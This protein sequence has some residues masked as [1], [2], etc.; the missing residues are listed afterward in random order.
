MHSSSEHPSIHFF[1]SLSLSKSRSMLTRSG[2]WVVSKNMNKMAK[3]NDLAV[4]TMHL[5][6]CLSWV[7][8]WTVSCL[9]LYKVAQEKNGEERRRPRGR[10]I[11]KGHERSQLQVFCLLGDIKEHMISEYTLRNSLWRLLPENDRWDKI[12]SHRE[13][14][15]KEIPLNLKM[16]ATCEMKVDSFMWHL[17]YLCKISYSPSLYS[18]FHRVLPSSFTLLSSIIVITKVKLHHTPTFIGRHWAKQIK[19]IGFSFLSACLDGNV[20]IAMNTLTGLQWC[21]APVKWTGWHGARKRHSALFTRVICIF[22]LCVT[23]VD[24]GEK[25]I[26]KCFGH[27]WVCIFKRGGRKKKVEPQTQRFT[28]VTVTWY[29]CGW[30]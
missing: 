28:N 23:L 11:K 13:D 3:E 20:Q 6:K 5:T 30:V 17:K 22:Q 7:T 9:S 26:V 14:S 4:W 27:E 29:V 25:A 18:L 15:V 16:H 8:Q 19:L 24:S 2:S 10:R 12:K 21:G 1:L